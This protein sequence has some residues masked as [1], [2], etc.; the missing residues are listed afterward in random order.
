M[1]LRMLFTL[2][3]TRRRRSVERRNGLDGAEITKRLRE[4]LDTS[5]PIPADA[6]SDQA[7][8]ENDHGHASDDTNRTGQSSL[9]LSRTTPRQ[10][11]VSEEQHAGV[12]EA[13]HTNRL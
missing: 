5:Q 9:N 11:V 12:D 2:L 1:F 8:A 7:R 3:R 13:E 6:R 10:S 4:L